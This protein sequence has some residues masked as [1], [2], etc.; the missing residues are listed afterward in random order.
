[1]FK[2]IFLSRDFADFV[3]MITLSPALLFSGY[4]I[5]SFSVNPQK[6]FY[7][8]RENGR[9]EYQQKLGYFLQVIIMA[10]VSYLI[11]GDKIQSE[12]VGDLLRL[13]ILSLLFPLMVVL[14]YKNQI[15]SPGE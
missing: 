15:E 14:R 8:R 1:M 3:M 6:F 13:V 4:F 12:L 9:T 5:R 2:S 7:L 11:F 10:T